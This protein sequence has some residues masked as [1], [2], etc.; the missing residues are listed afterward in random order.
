MSA[1]ASAPLARG[2]VSSVTSPLTPPT[3]LTVLAL[4]SGS[5]SLKFG[6]YRVD[7]SGATP[8]LTGEAHAIGAPEG[9]FS[10][11]DV[12]DTTHLK[13]SLVQRVFADQAD[14][15]QCIIDTLATARLPAVAAVGHRVVHGG[16][17]RRAH[18]LIDDAVLH[19]LAEAAAFA[20]LH[21]PAA[22]A[23]IAIARRHFAKLPHVACIDTVFHADMPD[24][25]RIFPVA[26]SLRTHGIERYGFH[27][28][29]CES[30]VRQVARCASDRLVVAHLG[31]GASVTAIKNG[32][33]IDTSM[34]LTPTGGVAMSSR[35]GDIDPGAMIYWLRQHKMDAA[36]LEHVLNYESGLLGVSGVSGDLRLLHAAASHN[37]NARLAVQLFC[38]SVRKQIAA[39]IAALGGVDRL[40]FTGGI[41]END[42]LVRASICAG[43]AWVGV[44]I[45]EAKNASQHACIKGTGSRVHVNVLPSEEAQQIA[46][47]TWQLCFAE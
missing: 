29:S 13:K 30:I 23:V 10:W 11:V 15:M 41:G 2:P 37:D 28:L 20:P 26:A 42:P 21:A 17:E 34:G 39:M 27:G 25:A 6:V 45:N 14:A 3:A 31:N 4:N 22:L 47:H 32:K 40:V 43:L 46:H 33:S 19:D 18:C 1:T 8:L 7:A 44:A 35:S 9:Q 12:R 5:S 36:Q 38:Y 24:V 16:P